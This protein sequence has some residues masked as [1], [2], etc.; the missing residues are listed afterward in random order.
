[1]RKIPTVSESFSHCG[2]WRT[3]NTASGA[4]SKGGGLNFAQ[5]KRGG[6][7]S[8][9]KWLLIAPPRRPPTALAPLAPVLCAPRLLA[10]RLRTPGGRRVPRRRG[11]GCTLLWWRLAHP[12]RAR[13]RLL[14]SLLGFWPYS[15]LQHAGSILE[16]IVV[17][18]VLFAL[19]DLLQ[20]DAGQ[21][22]EQPIL[23]MMLF[24]FRM[25]ASGARILFRFGET[26]TARAQP[27]GAQHSRVPKKKW[28]VLCF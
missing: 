5:K 7:K 27:H 14:L 10:P 20:G 8:A 3:Q 15:G 23:V 22:P 24:C 17:L 19:Q 13:R 2:E 18:R 9:T 25:L 6:L 16:L 28:W 11:G 1:M 4:C 26:Q 12:L 21:V